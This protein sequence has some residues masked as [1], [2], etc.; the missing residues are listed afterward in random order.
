MSWFNFLVFIIKVCFYKI[1][2]NEKVLQLIVLVKFFTNLFKIL[3]MFIL[4]LISQNYWF[5]YFTF[6]YFLNY[7]LLEIIWILNLKHLQ[8]FKVIFVLFLNLFYD[9]KY[10][11]IIN[12]MKR[13][14]CFYDSFSQLH[15]ILII[16]LQ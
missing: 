12:W 1:F 8:Y 3:L 5:F 14:F 4:Y 10:Q 9:F 11:V 16:F 15:K 2:I 7:H 13:I 6:C